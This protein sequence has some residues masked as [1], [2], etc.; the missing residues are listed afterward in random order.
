MTNFIPA[1]VLSTLLACVAFALHA[2]TPAGL[3]AAWLLCIIDTAIGGWQAFLILSL[4]FFLTAMADR[5]AGER[6]D[7]GHVRRK[8]GKR[9]AIRILCNVGIASLAVVLAAVLHSR[10]FL[11]VYAAVMVESLADSLASKLGPLSEGLTVDICTFKKI[12]PGLSGGVSITGTAAAAIGSLIISLCLLLYPWSDW[13]CVLSAAGCG[14]LG[15]MFDSA[16]GSL[17]Q[18][19]YRCPVCGSIV[20]GEIHCGQRTVQVKGMRFI[21]NDMVNL[22]GNAFSFLLEIIFLAA[23]RY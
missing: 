8:S 13:I 3:A 5:Y 7:P 9:D 14:F 18:L 6:A 23:I 1:A 2:I 21:N 17:I 11:T 20:E 16:A 4:T 22:L 10:R 12:A 15:C 19:K